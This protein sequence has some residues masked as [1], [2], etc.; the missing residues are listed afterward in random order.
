M[1]KT[2][3][4]FHA[5]IVGLICHS[6]TYQWTRSFDGI[7]SDDA[8]TIISDQNYN[9]ITTGVFNTEIDLDPGPVVDLHTSAGNTDI[10]LS[11][12]DVNGNY[13]WGFSI[14]GTYTDYVSSVTADTLGDLYVTGYFADSID[15]DPSPSSAIYYATTDCGFVAKYST[16]GTFQWVK[17]FGGAGSV[18]PFHITTSNSS[19][20]Y[21]SGS[22]SDSI[23]FNPDLGVDFLFGP[24]YQNSFI[25]KL[26]MSGNFEWVR[27][28]R[29]K[30]NKHSTNI[31][32]DIALVGEFSD[33]VDLDPTPGIDNHI[34]CSNWPDLF[35][36]RLDINGQFAWAKSFGG[37]STEE[38]YDTQ[39]DNSGNVITVG[40]CTGDI[41]PS[42]AIY[43]V[44]GFGNRDIFIQKLDPNGNFL[45][46]Q[47]YGSTVTDEGRSVEI[48]NYGNIYHAGT[49]TGNIDFDY[50]ASVSALN[51]SN[52]SDIFIQKL[53]PNGQ[54]I[55]VKQIDGSLSTIA[56][57]LDEHNGY[58]HLTGYFNYSVDF[59]PDISIDTISSYNNSFDIF[60]WKLSEPN[61]SV[62]EIEDNLQTIW[63]NPTSGQISIQ[64][65]E[66]NENILVDVYDLSGRKISTSTF[67]DTNYLEL[68]LTEKSGMYF[69]NISINGK[70]SIAKIIKE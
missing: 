1:K 3:I 21:I 38:A 55:W 19:A 6:Q 9:V 61:A 56:K 60:V 43:N 13:L 10:F 15:F 27:H 54:L 40:Y 39:M 36:T 8:F 18:H 7:Y 14:G 5:F 33:T 48:D 4:I 17:L 31:W 28:I 25:L 20:L 46:G 64:L 30:C 70:T 44:G 62:F 35:L 59:N 42:P 52:P 65:N 24:P 37:I 29:A 58:V 50:G 16:N 2:I 49:F 67:S 53:D 63:P 47:G 22:F 23:D 26:D 57:D 68:N 69:L 34:A 41:D 51:C 12:L 32:G 11:K 66:I 45:W